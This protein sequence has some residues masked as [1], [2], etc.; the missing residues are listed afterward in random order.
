LAVKKKKIPQYELP[1]HKR[2]VLWQ[3]VIAA[4]MYPVLMLNRV[5]GLNLNPNV[6]FVLVII[7][8]GVVVVSSFWSLCFFLTE[9]M[10]KQLKWYYAIPVVL[11]GIA[12]YTLFAATYGW[13]PFAALSA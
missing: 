3:S 9:V 4:L 2:M 11:S 8:L 5:L 1:F 12:T 7:Y 10:Q 6:A 13:W